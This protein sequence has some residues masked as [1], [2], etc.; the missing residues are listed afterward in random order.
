MGSKKPNRQKV[1]VA[2]LSAILALGGDPL[3]TRAWAEELAPE[4][5]PV[6]AEAESLPEAGEVLEEEQA[7]ETEAPAPQA[8]ADQAQPAVETDAPADSQEPEGNP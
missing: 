3:A 6:V 1:L 7:V 5:A 8:P 4:P 2:L